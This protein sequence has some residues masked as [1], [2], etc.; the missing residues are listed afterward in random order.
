MDSQQDKI[1]Q[2]EALEN[3]Y[4][5][6]VEPHINQFIAID[7]K[8]IPSNPVI[9]SGFYCASGWLLVTL[10][11]CLGMRWRWMMLRSKE[12]QTFRDYS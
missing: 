5:N 11:Y 2:R 10:F 3:A 8:P 4:T 9:L 1:K 12:K 6:F 7:S